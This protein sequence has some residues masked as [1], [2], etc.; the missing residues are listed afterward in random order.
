M[1]DEDNN[2]SA[3]SEQLLDSS[4]G[5]RSAKGRPSVVPLVYKD[6][7]SLQKAYMPFVKGGGLFVPTTSSYQMNEEVFLLVTLPDDAKPKPVPGTVV[8]QSPSSVDGRKRGVGV[9]FKGR[10]G[11]SMRSRIEGLLGA[12]VSSHDTTYTM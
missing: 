12:K 4:S 6:R 1:A 10:E 8:W 3:Q 7:K 5:D 2:L 11:N 9:E